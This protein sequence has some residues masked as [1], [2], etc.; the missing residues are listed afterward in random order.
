MNNYQRNS[1]EDAQPAN[2]ERMRDFHRAQSAG[3]YPPQDYYAEED[4]YAPEDMYY[5]PAPQYY[6]PAPRRR[7][8]SRKHLLLKILIAIPLIL[9]LLLAIAAAIIWFTAKPPA[10]ADTLGARKDG[11]TTVLLAGT[12]VQG[13]N[14]DVLMVAYVNREDKSVRLLS[15]PRDT[16]VNRE[17]DV[18]KINGAYYANGAGEKGMDAL[19]DYVKDVIGYRPDG[20]VLLDLNCFEELVDKFGG[21]EFDVPVDMFYEDPSQDLLIDLPAGPQKLDGAA[22]MW[23]MR[24]RSGYANGDLGRVNI[25][26]E[27]FK[28]ALSQWVSAKNLAKLPS[29]LKLLKNN[30]ETNLKTENLTW[31]AFSLFICRK[32]DFTCDTLPGDGVWVGESAGVLYGSYYAEDTEAA[33]KLISGYYN[34]YDKEITANDLHPFGK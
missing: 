12:D 8:K 20:Y 13:T 3:Y 9:L 14:T 17:S 32:G 18:P 24:F 22:A 31:L 4:G 26:Q 28:E 11:C 6:A 5:N 10:A 1:Y 27:F 2:V 7:K 30:C 25:Q 29:V 19:L 15:I 16:M 33:A 34:P 21:L 23:L